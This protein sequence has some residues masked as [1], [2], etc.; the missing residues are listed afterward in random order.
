MS[1]ARGVTMEQHEGDGLWQL[2]M[3]HSPIGMA[4]V[5]VDG[6]LLTVNHAF[7]EMLGRSADELAGMSFTE[8]THPDDLGGDLAYFDRAMDGEIDS[9]RVRKRYLHADGHLVWGDLSAVVLRHPDGSPQHM[10]AQILDVTEQRDREDELEAARAEVEHERQTLEAIF[11]AVGVGLLV[12]GPDGEY[13][14]MNQRHAEAMKVPFPEGH[15][16]QAGHVGHVFFA[17]GTTPM[18]REDLPSY[19]A[20]QGE[21]FDDCTNWVGRD[22]RTRLAFSTSARAVRAPSGEVLGAALA[23][24]EVTELMRLIQAKD[25]FVASVSHELRT[26]LTSVLGYL[27]ILADDAEIPRRVHER[28]QVVHRNALR[29]QALVRDLLEVGQFTQHGLTLQ[30]AEVDVARVVREAAEGAQSL[31]ARAQVA[32]FVDLPDRLIAR[33]DE[34]RVRQVLDNLL[35]NAVKYSPGG[36]EVG[37][38]LRH[39]AEALVL[40]VS[41]SGMGI[42]EED[43]P[44]V[45]DRF[46]RSAA[47]RD[48]HIPGTGLG[49]AIVDTVVTAHHGSV[50]VDSEVGRGT[51]FRVLLPIE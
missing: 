19:R 12:I 27:E 47:A 28:L 24:H 16:G 4:L 36:G 26:P 43:V 30:R 38:A 48:R 7:T 20:A 5:D 35:S 46:F 13:R 25:D 42:P 22:R 29:L 41:D 6:C 18:A 15:S 9:Y 11:D 23:Y 21:E 51:T 40:E 14:R 34:H 39:T 3:Q 31:T 33:V 1:Q 2:T 32:V 50:T 17:D 44:L 37:I 8:F 49:L 10:V 45:F